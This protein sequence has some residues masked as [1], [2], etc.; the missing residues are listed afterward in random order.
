MYTTDIE[1][2]S[3]IIINI[4][5]NLEVALKNHYVFIVK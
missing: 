1:Q 5:L 3:I 4:V 2:M